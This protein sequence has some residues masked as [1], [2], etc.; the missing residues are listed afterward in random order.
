M[1]SKKD[2]MINV[3]T[4]ETSINHILNDISID[5]PHLSVWKFI[6]TCK[7]Y[8]FFNVSTSFFAENNSKQDTGTGTL[9]SKLSCPIINVSSFHILKSFV[10]FL[11]C[12]LDNIAMEKINVSTTFHS[13]NKLRYKL[14]FTNRLILII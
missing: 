10:G 8:I 4:T 9:V 7:N 13:L 14:A 11:K 3:S 12:Y 1:F 5:L 6:M 2:D